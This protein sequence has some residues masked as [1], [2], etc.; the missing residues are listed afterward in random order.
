MDKN[1]EQR[2]CLKFCVLSEISCAEAR[3]MLQKAYGPATISKTRAYEWY[4]AFKDGREIVDD[5][6]RSGRP[7]TS[8][9]D[10]NVEEVKKIVLANRHVSIREIANN[11]SI[12]YGSAQRILV[13]V[14]GMKRMNGDDTWT[15]EC[16]D[17]DNQESSETCADI[18]PRAK[19]LRRSRSKKTA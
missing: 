16:D 12:S 18:E 11:L 1:V 3:K 5:L 4:K 19:K 13:D 6:H 15:C 2:H 8:N 17:L 14:L 9:T 7:S 10:K